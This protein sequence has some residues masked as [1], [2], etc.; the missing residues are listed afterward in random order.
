ME[1][2]L[3][4]FPANPAGISGKS[5]RKMI[6]PGY[7]TLPNSARLAVPDPFVGKSELW[8]DP[9]MVEKRPRQLYIEY[10]GEAPTFPTPVTIRGPLRP[11]RRRPPPQP[12]PEPTTTPS[13]TAESVQKLINED[14]NSPYRE[15]DI[16]K[17]LGREV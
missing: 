10:G 7:A 6:E 16:F 3:A 11:S 9:R 4:Q 15:S 14:L 5:A 17:G 2:Y 8:G 13:T 1:K 12:K